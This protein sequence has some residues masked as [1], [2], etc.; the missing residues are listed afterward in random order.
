MLSYIH[1]AGTAHGPAAVNHIIT[2]EIQSYE[3]SEEIY[4]RLTCNINDSCI[5]DDRSF[6]E[7]V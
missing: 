6:R 1:T 7:V 4:F 2:E 3:K 5:D